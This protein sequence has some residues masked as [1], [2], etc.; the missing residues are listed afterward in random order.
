MRIYVNCG[1]SRNKLTALLEK[2]LQ[3]NSHGI[4][5]HSLGITGIYIYIYICDF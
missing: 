4:E 1:S 2:I 5:A 3:P